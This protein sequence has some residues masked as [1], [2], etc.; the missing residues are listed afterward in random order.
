MRAEHS[1]PRQWARLTFPDP[2]SGRVLATH[3]VQIHDLS[4]RGARLEHTVVLRPG[5]TCVLRVPLEQQAVTMVGSV[6]WSQVVGRTARGTDGSTGLRYQS[7]LEFGRL[8][9]ET[10]DRLTAFLERRGI[11]HQEHGESAPPAN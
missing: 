4:L 7:G 3:D 5:S 8:A 10:H 1:R 2:V 9:G 11:L 6:V